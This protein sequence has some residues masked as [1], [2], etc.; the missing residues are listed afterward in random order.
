MKE[1]IYFA[2]SLF[3]DIISFFVNTLNPIFL[4]YTVKFLDQNSAEFI[5]PLSYLWVYK[6]VSAPTHTHTYIYIYIYTYVC[7]YV[8]ACVCVCIY[9]TY[10]QGGIT[11]LTNHI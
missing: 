9:N 8:S 11:E 5:D 3:F 10:I 7:T 1:R 6:C 4:H 2:Q